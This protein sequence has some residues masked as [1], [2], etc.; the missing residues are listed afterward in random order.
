MHFPKYSGD[1]SF[2][3]SK[4]DSKAGRIME[5]QENQM[6]Y[7]PAVLHTRKPHSHQVYLCVAAVFEALYSVVTYYYSHLN[8]GNAWTACPTIK[9]LLVFSYD[10]KEG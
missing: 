4:Q 5:S 2:S 7:H 6:K 9:Y 8:T 10:K 3:V 1:N